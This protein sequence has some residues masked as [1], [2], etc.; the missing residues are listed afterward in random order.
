M[1]FTALLDACVL[2]PQPLRDLLMSLAVAD[3]YRAR[4]T[5]RIQEEWRGSVLETKP[6]LAQALT[7][8]QERMEWLFPD[9]IIADYQ[10]LVARLNLPD[11]GDRHVLA[12]AILGRADVIVTRNLKDFPAATLEPYGIEPQHPDQFIDHVLMRSSPVA[13]DAIWKMRARLNKPPYTPEAFL[14]LLAR[15]ELP[16]SV[17]T[18]RQSIALI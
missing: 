18:L 16:R 15:Q 5:A 13:L 2:Y 8:R 3:L 9:A 7:R 17:A 10:A 1:A 4:W 11:P 14:N 12:A 6:M